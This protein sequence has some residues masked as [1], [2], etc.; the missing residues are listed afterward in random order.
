MKTLVKS[1]LLIV[2][3]ICA[4]V[5]LVIASEKFGNRQENESLKQMEDTLKKTAMTCY[6]TEGVYPP[7]LEYMKDHYGIQID[8]NQYTVFYE[9]HGSNLMPR[10]TVMEVEE[11]AEEKP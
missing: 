4:A 2:L 1:L 8:T 9:V 7:S 3:P 6:A 5:V 11:D 10:I